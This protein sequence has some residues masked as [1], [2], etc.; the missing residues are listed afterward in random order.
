LGDPAF[1]RD[2]LHVTTALELNL[3]VSNV[4]ASF[5]VSDRVDVGIAIPVVHASLAGSSTAEVRPHVSPTPHTFDGGGAT[6]ATSSA[7][8]SATGLG[9]I[10]ARLKLNLHQT[11]TLAAAMLGDVRLP[12]GREEDFLGSGATTVRILGIVSGRSGNF[13]PHANVGF[14]YTNARSQNN[15]LLA[16]LGFD[17]LLSDIATLAVDLVTSFEAADSKLSLP[18]PVLFNAG[19]PE[20]LVQLTDI[21]HRKDNFIDASFGMKF[22]PGGANRVITNVLFPLV[23][24]GVR[25]GVMW[26]LG[27]ERTF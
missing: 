17:Q 16:T 2:V 19:G 11:P 27:V 1:E 25:P 26:T 6:A 20:E 15:R 18:A 12:T 13:S 8:G 4:F 7:S 3:I 9:D 10:T 23:E 21:P 24:S 5:G 22:S 14:L